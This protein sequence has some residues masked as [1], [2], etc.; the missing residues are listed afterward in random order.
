[1]ITKNRV[2]ASK[3][4]RH[5]SRVKVATE[6]ASPNVDGPGCALCPLSRV[7][8]G[9]EVRSLYIPGV[10]HSFVGHTPDETRTATLAAT[11]ATFDFFHALFG[12]AP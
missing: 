6:S 5:R 11:N 4:G 10:D 7:K 12:K 1:M 9:V 2:G 3:P 8:A